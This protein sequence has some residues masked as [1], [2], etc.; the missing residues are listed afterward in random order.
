MEE[1]IT[2]FKE[3]PIENF[4]VSE[5][6]ISAS[7]PVTTDIKNTEIPT[8][9]IKQ[10]YT[11]N[12]SYDEKDESNDFIDIIKAEKGI[13]YEKYKQKCTEVKESEIN[14]QSL[15][16]IPEKP[17]KC[18]GIGCPESFDHEIQYLQ[19]KEKPHQCPV[20]NMVMENIDFLIHHYG[21]AHKEQLKVVYPKV[22]NCKICKKILVNS[23]HLTS[24][25]KKHIKQTNPKLIVYKCDNCAEKFENENLL[26]CH[27]IISHK[28]WYKYCMKCNKKFLTRLSF[29]EHDCKDDCKVQCR[30][31]HVK[32]PTKYMHLHAKCDKMLLKSKTLNRHMITLKNNKKKE[33]HHCYECFLKFDDSIQWKKHIDDMHSNQR[34]EEE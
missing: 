17:Y 26:D 5:L 8:E 14:T 3:E 11:D 2:V 15:E 13:E 10:E 25:M 29:D 20:C 7:T 27:R 9:K 6:D 30:L 28:Y 12:S 21:R 19:H 4:I 16:Y 24:H 1:L 31:C 23:S 33:Q 18:K 32:F 34:M 22:Y